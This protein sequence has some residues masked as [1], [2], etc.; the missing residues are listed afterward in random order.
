MKEEI[1]TSRISQID[2]L[3]GIAVILVL[4]RHHGSIHYLQYIGWAG[5]DLFFVV[6]GFLV[7]SLI[8]REYELTKTFS[9]KNF[10]IRRGLKIY[11]LFYLF[12]GLS[13]V[14]L[15]VAYKFFGYKKTDLALKIL[16][17]LIFV[18]NYKEGLWAHTW[19]LGVE[20]HFYLC[21]SILLFL[22]VK[23]KPV[24][25]TVVPYVFFVILFA[26]LSLRLIHFEFNPVI[27]NITHVYPTHLRLDSLLFGSLLS[28]FYIFSTRF[29]SFFKINYM[30]VIVLLIGIVILFFT[31]RH[32][33]LTPFMITFGFTFVYIGF[34]LILSSFLFMNDFFQA[35]N[36]Y[37]LYRCITTIGK[38]SYSIYL[39]HMFLP[40][41]FDNVSYLQNIDYTIQFILYFIVSIVTG[42]IISKIVE[43]PVLS[44]RD[45]FFPRKAFAI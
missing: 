18:Q 9:I 8:F 22:I 2:L 31:F 42:A 32:F 25:I 36:R 34:G 24:W 29:H 10:L 1:N 14:F 43:Y 4:F 33:V 41:I 12:I 40:S 19:S 27:D 3:R 38:Y 39:F 30:K 15:L 23:L 35:L 17:E 28:Y 11:P 45:K 7:T 26:I 16:R 20:E 44:L 21:I 37:A 5:V 13:L 6:S